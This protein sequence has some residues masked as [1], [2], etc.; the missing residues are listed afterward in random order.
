[1]TAA[2][3][4]AATFVL[5]ALVTAGVLL[6]IN[7]IAGPPICVQP[8]ICTPPLPG[9]SGCG[10]VPETCSGALISTPVILVVSLLTA[11]L[12]GAVVARRA[13]PRSPHHLTDEAVNRD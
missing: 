8:A 1:M 12:A 4:V 3:R 2:V 5:T 11:A 10:P 13:T 6:V 7:L 9:E